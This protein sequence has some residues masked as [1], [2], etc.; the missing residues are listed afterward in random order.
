MSWRIADTGEVID[1]NYSTN[2][3][4]RLKTTINDDDSITIA[5][6]NAN[7]SL[8]KGWKIADESLQTPKGW[9]LAD[10]PKP[11]SNYS[12]FPNNSN[13]L[14]TPKGWRLAETVSTQKPPLYNTQSQNPF[15]ND[16]LQNA[17]FDKAN[18]P[19]PQ[20]GEFDKTK[21]YTPKDFFWDVAKGVDRGYMKIGAGINKALDKITPDYVQEY[22]EQ[23]YK[24]NPNLKNRIFHAMTDTK[25]NYYRNQYLIN[26]DNEEIKN[27]YVGLGGEIAGDPTIMLPLGIVGKTR[28]FKNTIKSGLAGAAIATPAGALKD[29]GDESVS[30]KQMMSNTLINAL[31]GG[32]INSLLAS[33][34]GNVLVN[35]IANAYRSA[36]GKEKV[37]YS[38]FRRGVEVPQAPEQTNS[39]FFESI[40][41]VYDDIGIDTPLPKANIT[42]YNETFARNQAQNSEFIKGDGFRMQKE[43]Q[44][45]QEI[46]YPDEIKSSAVNEV[47]QIPFSNEVKQ[48]PFKS[49]LLPPQNL[50]A[51]I[52]TDDIFKEVINLHKSGFKFGKDINENINL[53][54][55]KIKNDRLNATSAKNAQVPNN[56]LLP[57]PKEP[58]PQD[59]LYLNKANKYI[60]ELEQRGL[61][62]EYVAKLRNNALENPHRFSDEAI[63]K[64]EWFMKNNHDTLFNK[65]G[66]A[67]SNEPIPQSTANN[68]NVMPKVLYEDYIPQKKYFNDAKS[69]YPALRDDEVR[70]VAY[71]YEH[72]RPF[73]EKIKNVAKKLSDDRLKKEYLN[74][75]LLSP[76][77]SQK[78]IE[79]QRVRFRNKRL[80]PKGIIKKLNNEIDKSLAEFGEISNLIKQPHKRMKGGFI[81]PNLAKDMASSGV[82]A[83]IGANLDEENRLRGAMLGGLTGLAGSHMFSQMPKIAMANNNI[84]NEMIKR[85]EVLKKDLM[86]GRGGLNKQKI[87][88]I[89]DNLPKKLNSLDEFEKSIGTKGDFTIDT[90]VEKI[91]ANTRKIWKHMAGENTYLQ[92]RVSFS[93]AFMDTL[94]DPLFVIRNPIRKQN[95]Y[96]KT[97][98]T[99]DGIT[100]LMSIAKKDNGEIIHKTFFNINDYKFMEAINKTLDT[101]VL[102]YKLGGEIKQGLKTT[103]DRGLIGRMPPEPSSASN[104]S[105]KIIQN[106]SLNNNKMKGG[107]TTQAMVKNIVSSGIGGGIGAYSAPEDKKLE[108]FIIGALGGMGASNFGGISHSAVN[109]VKNMIKAPKGID[110]AIEKGVDKG[111]VGVA[112]K[113]LS[114]EASKTWSDIGGNV[115]NI[116][117]LFANTLD[118]S[119]EKVRDGVTGELNAMFNKYVNLSGVLNQLSKQD[120]KAFYDFLANNGSIENLSPEIR[121][122]ANDVRNQIIK[123]FEY[124]VGAKLVDENTAKEFSGNF[125]SRIYENE[126]L[127]SKFKD[128]ISSGSSAFGIDPIYK[129]GLEKTIGIGEY[130]RLKA[131]NKIAVKGD[132]GFSTEGKWILN[133]PY[134]EKTLL[135]MADENTKIKIR[136]DYTA[137]ERAKMGEVTDIARVLPQTLYK[138]ASRRINNEFLSKTLDLAKNTDKILAPDELLPRLIELEKAGNIKEIKRLGYQKIPD[139]DRFGVLKGKFLRRDVAYDIS[140]KID[141]FRNK[142]LGTK[143]YTDYLNAWKWAK[144]V[145]NTTGHFNNFVGNAFLMKLAGI[146]TR[147]LKGMVTNVGV[148]KDAGKFTELK[149]KEKLGNIKPNELM[150][151]NE[152]RAK[153][154]NY[155]LASNVGLFG[156]SRLNDMGIE[157]SFTFKEDGILRKIGKFANNM[158][159]AE[160]DVAR[161]TMFDALVKKGKTPQ[162]AKEFTNLLMPDYTRYMPPAIRKLKDFGIAPFISWTY[163]V[164]PSVFKL[165]GTKTGLNNIASTFALMFAGSYLMTGVNPFGKDMPDNNKGKYLPVYKKGDTV[166]SLK[167]DRV[168][169]YAEWLN[170]MNFGEAPFEAMGTMATAP[171]AKAVSDTKNLLLNR[172]I[173]INDFTNRPVT[174]S[175]KPIGE[176]TYDISKYMVQQHTP[177]P[178][179]ASNVWN[180]IESL[181]RTQKQR[182]TNDTFVPRSTTQEIIKLLGPNLS[183]HS[184][185]GLNADRKRKERQEKKRAK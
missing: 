42:P 162:E 147:E 101:N 21:S 71:T 62:P 168:I 35:K 110:K 140:Q 137:D 84:K 142:N 165:A 133:E 79:S 34:T 59:E 6:N 170:P 180:F 76:E 28:G 148:L 108:G 27:K 45:Q 17:V 24:E 44:Y 39:Q 185:K 11:L 106:Q 160:D 65:Q 174:Y 60:D 78:L 55:N 141:S 126:G 16:P 18:V 53:V 183:N 86:Y 61:K 105:G 179:T 74:K 31:A 99:K 144:T 19:M 89:S 153:F 128:W 58:L 100:N 146:E 70:Q 125:L 95:E 75:E 181:A 161:L 82:G 143:I 113:F 1:I 134:G 96:Y 98:K 2:R 88:E 145:G 138:M 73:Y 155:E 94:K 64:N 37:A 130:Q 149:M 122:F 97:F 127:K 5:P 47:K 178:A 8:P 29:Y 158:Y 32:G 54:L 114:K 23:K 30:N 118:K 154:K 107:F 182:K 22:W 33:K 36:R 157:N 173:P 43:P 10:E 102:Y 48:I 20:M 72:D 85:S 51:P 184:I 151:L 80:T 115:G 103:S 159:G 120:N 176:K 90:P 87:K 111:L 56:E 93:G 9:K 124:Q 67:P 169:P 164:I 4:K 63:E 83:G 13:S 167:I 52:T 92:D 38:N 129:R 81:T 123:E 66:K 112:N 171:I 14:A 26:K 177:L 50:K 40:K 104:P 136:R 57:Q 3:P 119:Y 131:L 91:N 25:N 175:N 166:T 116:K 41:N 117:Y 139:N 135:K 12:N 152:N 68:N 49:N 163:Y 132:K 121:K 77:Q 7:E 69:Q 15:I 46:I 150:W 109:L 172:K 156:R